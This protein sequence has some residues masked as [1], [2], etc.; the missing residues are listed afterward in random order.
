MPHS[1]SLLQIQ[2]LRDSLQAPSR[3][4][5]LS[6]AAWPAVAPAILP[7]KT[8]PQT[9]VAIVG[10]GL[11]GLVCADTLA[12]KGLGA[13]IY[14]AAARSGGRVYSLRNFF[15]GQVAERGGEFID[16]GHKTMI[17][18]ARKFGL[19][20]EDVNKEPGEVRY[21]FRGGVAS[22]RQVVEEFRALVDAMRNDLRQLS[23]EVTA[24]QFTPADRAFDELSL[25]EYLV[26][27]GAGPLIRAV[28]E[29]A[30]IAEYGLAPSQ[31]SCLNLLFFIHADRRSKFTP[32][33]VFSDERYH[34]VEG[35]DA[36]ASGLAAR[37]AARWRHGHKLVRVRKTAAERIELTF[38]T[39]GGTVVR[40]HE[41]VVLTLPF[42]TLRLVEL[43]ASLGLSAAKRHAI[44]HLGYGTNAKL[45]V[46]FEARPWLTIHR[47]NGASYS[48]LMNHQT[49][50]ETNPR[51]ATASRAI[52][53]DYSGAERG[54]NVNPA[55]PQAEAAKFLEDLNQVYP[56]A[57]AAA[58]RNSNGHLR[59]HL[60]H[61]PSN[62]LARGGYTCYRPGQF[63]RIAGL[64]GEAAGNLLF[65]GEHT[66]SFYEWQGFMEGACLSGIAA[67]Q[68]ILR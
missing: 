59:V 20:L 32:F 30:Y 5:F 4:A 64:E 63:T 39:P 46:G 68:Q 53:T 9:D 67:A 15:P 44:E 50:W 47:S 52:L 29:E 6:A 35:N 38:E 19:T 61:W 11:A 45:M 8:A 23:G 36:I 43:D 12:T 54:A 2:K 21:Y 62:P 57:L 56:G 51:L 1:Q 48:D 3:R 25:E 58:T 28:L 22:E 41:A 10:A 37:L 16:T 17:G 26:S 27:R 7:A 24:A 49:T 40:T 65:A 14:E 66:N 34:V 55:Q 60:E 33:G 31:Q 13:T 42:S 18:Y